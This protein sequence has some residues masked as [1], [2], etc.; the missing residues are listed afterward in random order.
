[1]QEQ[2]AGK[3]DRLLMRI[4]MRREIMTHAFL[5]ARPVMAVEIVGRHT[6]S[7]DLSLSL[8]AKR[9]GLLD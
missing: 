2:F 7:L 4:V 3:L 8:K 9:L 1:M 5:V 6:E